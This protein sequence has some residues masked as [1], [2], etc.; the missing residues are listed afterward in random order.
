M[1]VGFLMALVGL[2]VVL[3]AV[4]PAL[5]VLLFLIVTDRWYIKYEENILNETFGVEYERYKSS[6]RRW[7]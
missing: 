3:G 4:S 5:F 7:I 1:Y 6:T 2:F